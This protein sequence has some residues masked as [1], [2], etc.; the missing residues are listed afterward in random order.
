LRIIGG[1]TERLVKDRNE[2]KNIW[3]DIDEPLL[4]DIILPKDEIKKIMIDVIEYTN[5]LLNKI[6]RP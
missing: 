2:D 5:S 1:V 4:E 6:S 3:E